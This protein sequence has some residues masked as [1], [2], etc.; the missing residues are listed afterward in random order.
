MPKRDSTR[1]DARCDKT[2][3]ERYAETR[4][5]EARHKMR[6]ARRKKRRKTRGTPKQRRDEARCAKKTR[7]KARAVPKRNKTRQGTRGKRQRKKKRDKRQEICRSQRHE[8]RRER[9]SWQTVLTSVP[10]ATELGTSPRRTAM[11]KC[12]TMITIVS[13]ILLLLS[14][15]EGSL[16]LRNEMKATDPDQKAVLGRFW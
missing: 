11:P 16:K 3:D 4:R 1:Q 14:S 2:K 5:D 6:D 10:L 7:R 12:F 13:T 9:S 15:F 8:T